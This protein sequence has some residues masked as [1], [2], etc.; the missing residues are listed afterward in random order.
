MIWRLVGADPKGGIIIPRY[1]APV[2]YSPVS[3]RY[4]FNMGYD[5][6]YFTAFI[7]NLSSKAALVIDNS[8]DGDFS[9]EKQNNWDTSLAVGES[10]ILDTLFSKSDSVTMNQEQ[11]QL[12][13][14]SIAAHRKSLKKDYE[15]KYFVT[16]QW[17]QS[18][19]SCRK[20]AGVKFSSSL[21]LREFLE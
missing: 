7:I 18:D 8:A 20:Y 13:S 14:K 16:N 19:A 12:L 11:H 5:N 10:V 1:Q 17:D 15:N 4:V 9:V 2:S 21:T 6:K 3:M